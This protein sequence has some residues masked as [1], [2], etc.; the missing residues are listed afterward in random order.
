MRLMFFIA[1]AVAGFFAAAPEAQAQTT[2]SEINAANIEKRVALVIGNGAYAKQP[3]ANPGN[4]SKAIAAK[5]ADL[6]FRVVACENLGLAEMQQA[7]RRLGTLARGQDIAAVFFAGHGIERRGKNYLIPTDAVLDHA[8]DLAVE[9]LALDVVLE[10][11]AGAAKLRLVLLD[12]C[13]NNP[14]PLA[15]EER[16]NTRGLA[17]IAAE[18]NTLIAFAAKA[19][20]VAADGAAGPNSPFTASL[21]NRLGTPGRDIRLVLGDVYQD[22]RSATRQQQTPEVYAQLGGD[23]VLRVAPVVAANSE[24]E[25]LRAENERLR[26]DKQ[27]ANMGLGAQ[28]PA[29]RP[30]PTIGGTG[31]VA[32]VLSTSIGKEDA[33]KRFSDLQTKYPDILSGRPAEVQEVNLGQT[34][35]IWYR[36]VVGPI[37]SRTEAAQVCSKLQEAGYNQCFAIPY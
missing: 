35:G 3:L 19:G 18:E 8:S 9:A 10:R 37:G 34:K 32:A 28:K 14:F 16:G 30:T 36:A 26:T 22:V 27:T 4:D 23:V 33:M 6:G 20:T 15:G 1:V 11:L 24:V 12:A 21:I 13:R 29:A 5:L 7:L 31:F 25:R 2:C 17:P